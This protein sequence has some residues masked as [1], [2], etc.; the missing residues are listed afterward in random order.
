[1]NN[2]E[3]FARFDSL[4]ELPISEEVLGA[5]MEGNANPNEVLQIEFEMS[6]NSNLSSFIEELANERGSILDNLEN[7][8]FDPD[9]PHFLSDIELPTIE[10]DAFHHS[11]YEDHMVAACCPDD[12]SNGVSPLSSGYLHDADDFLEIN[13]SS[14]D[15]F[16]IEDQSLDIDSPE[17]C[18]DMFNNDSIDI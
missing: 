6:E 2:E 4:E 17:E 11:F 5:Y 12:F 8:I 15:S 1:M 7:Q 13:F 18:D 10:N 9:Y 16:G 14:E 3:L